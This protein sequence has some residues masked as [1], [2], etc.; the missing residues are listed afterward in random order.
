MED[1]TPSQN[2]SPQSEPEPSGRAGAGGGLDRR[3]FVTG[4]IAQRG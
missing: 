4:A 1:K 3:R 2:P